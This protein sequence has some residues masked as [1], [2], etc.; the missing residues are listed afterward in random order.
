MFAAMKFL[1]QNLVGLTVGDT[2]RDA[3]L[4]MA[5]CFLRRLKKF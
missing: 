4:A 2:P 5:S 3:R 1:N